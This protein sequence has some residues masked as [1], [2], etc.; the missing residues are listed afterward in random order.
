MSQ[1]A[2]DLAAVAADRNSQQNDDQRVEIRAVTAE[3]CGTALTMLH[4]WISRD[5]CLALATA[6]HARTPMGLSRDST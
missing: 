6:V 3:G 4:A 2:N 5:L 1:P